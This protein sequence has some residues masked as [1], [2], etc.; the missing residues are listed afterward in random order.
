MAVAASALCC[1]AEQTQHGLN[2][3]WLLLTPLHD[4]SSSILA[5]AYESFDWTAREPI[6]SPS[7]YLEDCLHYLEAT[8]T[9]LHS[10]PVCM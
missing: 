6:E 10:I 4:L 7:D 2:E 9:I 1:N 5:A 3:T 8:F